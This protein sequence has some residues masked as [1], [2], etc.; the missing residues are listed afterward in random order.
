VIQVER[1]VPVI[2]LQRSCNGSLTVDFQ[3]ARGMISALPAFEGGLLQTLL[4]PMVCGFLQRWIAPPWRLDKS[5][6]SR[7]GTRS[8]NGEI[9]QAVALA[10]GTCCAVKGDLWEGALSNVSANARAA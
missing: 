7:F 6:F 8:Y 10:C 2:I 5:T 9:A 1:L 4:R 3:D